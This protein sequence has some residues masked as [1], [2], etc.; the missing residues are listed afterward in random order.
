MQKKEILYSFD[1]III[2]KNIILG[3]NEILDLK[4]Y[5]KIIVIS[6][7]L[8]FDIYGKLLKKIIKKNVGIKIINFLISPGE[9]N[10]N[11]TT[12]YDIFNFLL[13]NNVNKNDLIVSFGGGVISDI[14]GFVSKLFKRGIH[15][16]NI[17]TTL[18]CSI[19]AAI[20]E[21]NGINLNNHKNII[22]TFNRP[23]KIIIDL[24]FFKTESK[25]DFNN[26]L[27]EIIKISIV[28][29][30]SLFLEIKKYEE[31][32]LAK[33]I[34]IS[35]IQ[36]LKITKLDKFDNNERK[37]LNFGHT[38]A[39]S[40]E[41]IKNYKISHGNAVGAGIIIASKLSFYLGFLDKNTYK[42]IENLVKK[43]CQ[44]DFNFKIKELLPFITNDKKINGDYIDITLV[45]SLGKGFV[46]KFKTKDFFNLLKTAF[47]ENINLQ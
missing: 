10:K 41:S 13:K 12:I 37:I 19:D 39:H 20:G 42:D 46:K 3:I 25:T 4:N 36:K 14:S 24:E 43:Y 21:K 11:L 6:D 18:L 22:G 31:K 26:G 1:N 15:Y 44:L 38:F 27:I 45:S 28:S 35:I 47:P 34:K 5:S 17:P 16:I 33:I 32:N 9:N 2:G 7:T 23:E 30:K 29:N 40:I 8:I